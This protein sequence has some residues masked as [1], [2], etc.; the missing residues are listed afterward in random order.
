MKPA[1]KNEESL[2]GDPESKSINNDVETLV[3]SKT[4]GSAALFCRRLKY[5][6]KTD[7]TSDQ[8]SSDTDTE[9]ELP[10]STSPTPGEDLICKL[11]GSEF[12]S[13]TN[14]VR[15]M[16]IHTGETPYIC[17]VCGKGFKRQGS[18][19][20]HFSVHT[21]VKRKREKRLSCD[22]CEMKFNSSTAL[23]SH[24]NKH[25]GERPFACVQCDKTYFN[26][27]DLNQHLRDCHSDKK[28]GCYLCGYEFTR[29]SSL[30]KHMRIH[31]GERPYSC[32]HCGKTFPYKHSM[33]MHI[34]GAVCRSDS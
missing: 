23:R 26:Q 21:G 11:C 5:R 14:M 1:I 22:Q 6:V 30:Q 18:L 4:E 16:R 15:H 9:D 25:R 24:L 17:E 34:K 12:G 27:H 31:T 2:Q 13:N 28:H 33:K 7:Q 32:P 10:I 3:L 19:K 29:Q 8:S 20:E